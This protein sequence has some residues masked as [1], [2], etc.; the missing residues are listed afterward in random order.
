M[1]ALNRS[2][3]EEIESNWE[4]ELPDVA[5]VMS[6]DEYIEDAVDDTL[7][8]PIIPEHRRYAFKNEF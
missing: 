3:I 5:T 2:P 8:A 1:S 7:M 4:S 6:D